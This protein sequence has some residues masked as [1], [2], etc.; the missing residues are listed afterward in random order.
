MSVLTSILGQFHSLTGTLKTHPGDRRY[1]PHC[2]V[3]IPNRDAKNEDDGDC[4]VRAA[5]VSIP[6]RDAKNLAA[7]ARR[8]ARWQVSIP[9]RDA[10]NLGQ[11]V[12]TTNAH[13]FQSLIGTLKT[14]DFIKTKC[15][16]ERFNP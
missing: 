6:N 11:V 12:I 10:K 7:M 3:S 14:N 1:A 13:K 4:T 15:V 8:D 9:N 2:K 16:H 5:G